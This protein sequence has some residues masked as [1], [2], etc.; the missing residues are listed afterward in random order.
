MKNT[1][2]I[3]IEDEKWL[4]KGV[5]RELIEKHKYKKND[6]V[7]LFNKSP[8]LDI[9]YDDPEDIFHHSTSYWANF[10][11]TIENWKPFDNH[12]CGD[13]DSKNDGEF[14]DMK[15]SYENMSEAE[16]FEYKKDL[17]EGMIEDGT[18]ENG[19]IP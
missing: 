19:D 2:Q 14:Q 3:T 12:S 18:I 8:L 5:I 11:V 13:Y 10:L 9:L 16:K 7:N 17:Y 15:R 4:S 6:A 1:I